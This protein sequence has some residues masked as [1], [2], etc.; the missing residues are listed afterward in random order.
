LRFRFQIGC[1]TLL[2]GRFSKERNYEMKVMLWRIEFGD[3]WSAQTVEAANIQ[4]AMRKAR[5]FHVKETRD[6]GWSKKT[7]RLPIMSAKKVGEGKK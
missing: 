6:N 7:E 1:R 2:N 3:N 5:R 4:S